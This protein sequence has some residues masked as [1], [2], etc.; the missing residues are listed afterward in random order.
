MKS[1]ED[2]NIYSTVNIK[3]EKP[4]PESKWLH[5]NYRF[6]EYLKATLQLK[7]T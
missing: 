6:Y 2:N 3:N 1:K 7:S 5:I 4:S